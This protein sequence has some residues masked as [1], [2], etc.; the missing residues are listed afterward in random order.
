MKAT[1]MEVLAL[2]RGGEKYVFMYRLGQETELLRTF[3]RYASDQEL[4]FT[5]Y[6]AA[7]LSGQVNLNRNQKQR[8]RTA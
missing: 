3:G 5:W 8:K 6:D 1:R 7:K 4:S 2:V